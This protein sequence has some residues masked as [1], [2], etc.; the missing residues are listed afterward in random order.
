MYHLKTER[1]MKSVW[2]ARMPTPPELHV[3]NKS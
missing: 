3:G 1:Q 2:S